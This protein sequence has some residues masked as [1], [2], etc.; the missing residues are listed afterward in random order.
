MARI[1]IVMPQMGESITN[2]T[3]TKWNKN[4]G[5]KV[6]MDEILFEI[7]T[8]KVESEIPSPVEG[9]LAALFFNEGDTVDV[10]V[11]IAE[12]EDDPA[13]GLDA[14][15]AKKKPSTPTTKAAPER[16]APAVDSSLQ[17]D[18]GKRRFY[19]PLVKAMA[20]KEGVSISEL[21][22]IAGSGAGGRVNRDD[23][24][25]FL[26]QRSSGAGPVGSAGAKVGSFLSNLIKSKD[27]DVPGQAVKVVPMD[28]MRK[29][30]A[31]NMVLSKQ[32]SPHV[33]SVG[34]V[35]LTHLVRFREGIKNDFFKQ[36][37]FKITYTPFIMYAIVQAL[38]EF[39]WVNASID[40]DN[41]LIKREIHLGFAVAVPGSGLVVP[42]VKNADSLNVK[43]LA[44]TVD[45]LAQKAR[46]KKLAMD[47]LTGGTFTFSNVGSFGTV[48]A[49]P[50]ILQPQVGIYAAGVIQKRVMVTSGDAIAIRS[51]MYGTHTYDHRLIDGEMGGLFLNA[52]HQNLREMTPETMF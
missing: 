52:V 27:K 10:G 41:I 3:I 49:T 32:T 22:N 47:D 17:N 33:S 24:K 4:V 21:A 51:M 12:I 6:E 30:I 42:V 9:R 31:R 13:A 11:K 5:D 48:F 14:P 16:K 2:G 39:P 23:F 50:V 45:S 28:N 37:G 40:G 29:T 19:T 34:E 38:Q 46:A 44:R 36:E 20:K 43:G 15:S 25:N 26:S 8:D 1:D 35:D 7:S 18:K